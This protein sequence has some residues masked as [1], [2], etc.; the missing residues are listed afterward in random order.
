MKVAIGFSLEPVD[1][2]LN[3][4]LPTKK[5][6]RRLEET[7]KFAQIRAS[8]QEIDLI[9]PLT[10]T[11]EDPTTG[12]HHLL[13]GHIRLLVLRELGRT[14]APC[15]IAVDDESY[16]YNNQINRITAIQEHYMIRR[17]IERGVSPE[18]LASTLNVNVNLIKAKKALL[19]GIC[20]EAVQALQDR[21]FSPQVASTLRQMKPMRQLECID[22]MI[23]ANNLTVNYA[24]A[25]LL[26]SSE[27]ALLTI[28]KKPRAIGSDQ[29]GLMEREMSNV[30]EQYRLAEESYG[31]DV[32]HLVFAQ[33]YLSKLVGN[34]AV[35]SYLRANHS[36]VVEH[37]ARILKRI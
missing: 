31:E 10:I 32:L 1:L 9:E 5:I 2:P 30:H 16:T 20:A 26:A 18:R 23:A 14:S 27:D 28:K 7:S 11:A 22:L 19:D 3:K 13:D 12:A 33:G 35:F 25:L 17:A 21:Q 4:L 15:L 8:I 24:K 37:I 36:D 34:E 29:V 6:I